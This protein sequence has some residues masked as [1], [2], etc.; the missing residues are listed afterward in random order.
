MDS[1]LA[2]H[3]PTLKP[4]VE[5]VD[6]GVC[7]SIVVSGPREA[8]WEWSARLGSLSRPSQPA[9]RPNTASEEGIPLRRNTFILFPIQPT[10]QGTDWLLWVYQADN[11]K[12]IGMGEWSGVEQLIGNKF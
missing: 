7:G 5:A 2:C 4:L 1:I 3:A 9:G 6:Q 12:K 8:W 10:N 11:I